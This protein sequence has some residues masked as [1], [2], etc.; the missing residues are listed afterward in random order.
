MEEEQDEG[1]PRWRQSKV[2]AEQGEGSAR[3]K[4]DGRVKREVKVESLL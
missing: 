4:M 1:R 2:G 3:Q